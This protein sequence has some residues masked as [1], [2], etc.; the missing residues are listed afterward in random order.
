MSYEFC[1]WDAKATVDIIIILINQVVTLA[2]LI[3][4]LRRGMLIKRLYVSNIQIN[5][6]PIILIH[7]LTLLWC[8]ST[9]AMKKVSWLSISTQLLFTLD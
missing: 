4:T 2:L 9:F 3:I 6:R 5:A 8:L 7:S 1:Y